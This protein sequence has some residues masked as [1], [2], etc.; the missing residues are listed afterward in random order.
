MSEFGAS[1][2][3]IGLTAG[4]HQ[5]KPPAPAEVGEP[6]NHAVVAGSPT[7]GMRPVGDNKCQ[8]GLRNV[9]SQLQ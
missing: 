2:F 4:P 6:A 8:R 3:S 5:P 7:T 9:S 1:G